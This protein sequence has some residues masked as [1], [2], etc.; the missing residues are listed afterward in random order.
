MDSR[1]R[2]SLLSAVGRGRFAKDRSI[3]YLPVT[4]IS[5]SID[6]EIYYFIS[7]GVRLRIVLADT[8]QVRQCDHERPSY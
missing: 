2:R 8:T 4:G 3:T 7:T 1:P 5:R 6:E